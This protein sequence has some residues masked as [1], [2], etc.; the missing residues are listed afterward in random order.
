M[1][2]LLHSRAESSG[3][4]RRRRGGATDANSPRSDRT[5]WLTTSSQ[6]ELFRRGGTGTVYYKPTRCPGSPNERLPRVSDGLWNPRQ[7]PQ[8]FAQG[9]PGGQ[10]ESPSVGMNAQS[11]RPQAPDEHLVVLA[12][13]AE[14]K[15]LPVE[16]D[17]PNAVKLPEPARLVDDRICGTFNGGPKRCDLP[18]S[19]LRGTQPPAADVTHELPATNQRRPPFF[20]CSSRSRAILSLMWSQLLPAGTCGWPGKTMR[21]WGLPLS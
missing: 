15:I 18:E 16:R 8:L 13:P 10:G 4:A 12:K 1:S 21:S 7:R 2:W 19:P 5:G 6:N 9:R 11:V 3:R 14:R 17:R 20:R